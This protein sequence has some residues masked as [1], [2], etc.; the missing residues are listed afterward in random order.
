LNICVIFVYSETFSN[1]NSEIIDTKHNVHSFYGIFGCQLLPDAFLPFSYYPC[2]VQ[3]NA[4]S[5]SKCVSE[6]ALSVTTVKRNIQTRLDTS[7]GDCFWRLHVCAVGFA[8][9]YLTCR[10][11][12]V[13]LHVLFVA[14]YMQ[15]TN[16][17]TLT[18]VAKVFSAFAQLKMLV[19][20]CF[21]YSSLCLSILYTFFTEGIWERSCNRPS[22]FHLHVSSSN[23]IQEFSVVESVEQVWRLVRNWP[24]MIPSLQTFKFISFL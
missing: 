4:F 9:G 7:S 18:V 21:A 10:W 1:E 2:S 17:C 6:A 11:C 19:I 22:T 8:F 12:V 13:N 20:A 23:I 5:Y 14:P 24:N 16:I 3:I 15:G